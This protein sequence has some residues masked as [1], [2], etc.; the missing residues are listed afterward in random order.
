MQSDT[1]S[2]REL[3]VLLSQIK[4]VAKKNREFLERSEW[5]FNV[6]QLCGVNRLENMHSKI[7]A[8]FL[9]PSESHGLG[10]L[11]LTKFFTLLNIP[12]EITSATEVTT[13]L[14][15]TE[16][17]MD[18]V[19]RDHEL[20]WCVVI[21]NKVDAPEQSEQL[22]RYWRWLCT[23]YCAE[24]VR[25]L[26]LTLDGHA[27]ETVGKSVQYDRISYS[28]HIIQWLTECISV[29]AE[30]PFVRE[31]LRQYRNH[32]KSL[33]G[34]N[35]EEQNM[36]EVIDLLSDA[37]NF[38]AAQIIHDNYGVACQRIAAGI[39]SDV[40]NTLNGICEIAPNAEAPNLNT[41]ND[42]FAFIEPKSG[43]TIR[44]GPEKKGFRDFFVGVRNGDENNLE[45]LLRNQADKTWITNNEWWPSYKYLPDPFR[46]WS[47]ELLARCLKDK[48]FRSKLVGAIVSLVKELCV[49]LKA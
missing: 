13:E 39:F 41:T 17:R 7:L 21:E 37:D 24:N 10:S 25:L 29:A 34:M 5:S 22:S 31:T 42:G 47:G 35:L 23:N 46:W 16:G 43:V 45:T 11:C 6:F 32:I 26:F 14:S 40:A 38:E 30:R 12:F 9:D 4:I 2:N 36:N 49:V 28:R 48:T 15:K 27:S 8:T 18:I 3:N 20:G 19:I 33:T 44:I 1:T